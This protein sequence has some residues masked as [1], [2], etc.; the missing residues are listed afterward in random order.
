MHDINAAEG[1]SAFPPVVT[2][3]KWQTTSRGVDRLRFDLN[4]LDHTPFGR[5]EDWEDSPAGWPQTPAY[6]WWR[7]HD[8][9]PP[10]DHRVPA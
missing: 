2:P 4:V 10:E 9:Y 1:R 6:C 7:V 5:Q 8:E 3:E